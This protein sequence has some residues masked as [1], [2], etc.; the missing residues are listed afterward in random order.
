MATLLTLTH[1]FLGP[2]ESVRVERGHDVYVG[3][4][5]QRPHAVVALLVLR[6]EV[7]G[8]RQHQLPTDHLVAVHVGHVLQHGHQQRPV[9]RV[10]VR[11][12]V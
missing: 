3:G 2:L 8:Q 10:G 12:C 7:L 11:A 4:V 9:L 5:E 1:P 6:Q